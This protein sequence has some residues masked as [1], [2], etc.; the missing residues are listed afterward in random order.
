MTEGTISGAELAEL[1]SMSG[2]GGVPSSDL[3]RPGCTGC[4]PSGS[5]PLIALPRLH[6]IDCAPRLR[7]VTYELEF[8]PFI[9]RN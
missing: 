6:A 5:T 7:Q 9:S 2:I 4:T 1:Y 3:H 8:H